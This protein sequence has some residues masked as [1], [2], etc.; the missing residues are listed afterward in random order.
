[1]MDGSMGVTGRMS[2]G[3]VQHRP[4]PPSGHDGLTPKEVLGIL[5]RHVLLIIFMTLLGF[6]LG[7]AT[8]YVLRTYMPSYRA[9]ALIQ[10]LPP[11]EI[12]PTEISQ[13]QP[14]KDRMYESRV[15]IANL[16][17]QQ[18]TY[19][20]LLQRDLVRETQWYKQFEGNQTKAILDLKKYL[21]A[22]PHRDAD[23]VS[24]SMTCAQSKEAADIVNEMAQ[25]FVKSQRTDKQ[26]DISE[27]LVEFE[28]GGHF[29]LY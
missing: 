5:R 17:K 22:Y 29:F 2:R 25:M 19:E 26:N 1:M 12:D 13:M 7:G 20:E 10:V 23:F 18:N 14:D 21:T 15:T 24:V 11:I 8:W 4:G 6:C 9:E 3:G 28:T 27:K 16:M